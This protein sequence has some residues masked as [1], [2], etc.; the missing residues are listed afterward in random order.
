MLTQLPPQVSLQLTFDQ[1]G[2]MQAGVL[3]LPAGVTLD[4][5]TPNGDGLTC[6]VILSGP[7]L[8]AWC[9]PLPPSGQIEW[10]GP[11]VSGLVAIEQ[12]GSSSSSS[13]GS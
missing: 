7:G 2:R 10:P 12:I 11:G 8:P 13:S 9:F 5:I 4:T 1:I 3:Q 6:T